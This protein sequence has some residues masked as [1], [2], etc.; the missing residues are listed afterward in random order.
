MH[1]R[2]REFPSRLL[3]ILVTHLAGKLNIHPFFLFLLLPTDT[4]RGEKIRRPIRNGGIYCQ[5]T[6]SAS[7]LVSRPFIVPVCRSGSLWSV[8]FFFGRR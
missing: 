2:I 5:E 1:D 3:H 7:N 8:F 6:L 4:V